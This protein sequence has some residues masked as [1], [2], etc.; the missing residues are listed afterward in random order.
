M[1]LRCSSASAWDTVMR[2]T[3]NRSHSSPLRRKLQLFR[4]DALVDLVAQLG[5]TLQDL[6]PVALASEALLTVRKRLWM[7]TA[8]VADRPYDDLRNLVADRRRDYWASQPGEAV[9]KLRDMPADRP[10]RESKE[11]RGLTA[12]VTSR[13][14]DFL[15]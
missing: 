1:L 11:Y 8:P 4:V 3:P 13:E 9:R 14:K 2:E 15:Q 6:L 12:R 5:G 7:T 10:V